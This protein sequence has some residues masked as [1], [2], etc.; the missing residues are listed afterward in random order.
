MISSNHGVVNASRE[1]LP[2]GH[3]MKQEAV[4]STGDRT[5]KVIHF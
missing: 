1:K 4:F 3:C 5:V 2:L